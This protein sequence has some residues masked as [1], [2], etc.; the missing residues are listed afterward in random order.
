MELQILGRNLELNEGIRKHISRKIDRLSRHLPAITTVKIELTR[1]NAR[2]QDYRVVAQLTLN[3]DGTVLRGEE[4]GANAM[5][6]VDSAISVM[7]RRVARY[8]GKVYKSEQVKKAGKNASIRTVDVPT[9]EPPEDPVGGELDEAQ[10]RVV[11]V[12]Q[13]PIKPMTPDD[14]VFQMELLGHDFFM[15]FNS[16]TEQHNVLYRRRDGDYGLIQPEPL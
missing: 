11:R 3:I 14:A 9:A 6:A 13:F 2:A 15:F 1:A 5:V 7:D 4:R 16:E 8:K 12:K 10:G